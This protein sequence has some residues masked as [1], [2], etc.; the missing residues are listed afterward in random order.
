MKKYRIKLNEKIYE[1]EV[2]LLEES[3]DMSIA[4]TKEVAKQSNP[5]PVPTGAGEQ[6]QAPL[7]GKVLDIRVTPG[8]QVK[9]GD[10][11]VILEAMKLENEIFSPCDGVVTDVTTTKGSSVTTGEC[12]IV[13]N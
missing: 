11:L 3:A 8:S 10:I 9:K 13:L 1:V 12:L 7:P 2:E 4:P 6:V 5:A